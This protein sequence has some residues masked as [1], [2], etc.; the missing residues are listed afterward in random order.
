MTMTVKAVPIRFRIIFS[1]FYIKLST[2]GS[3]VRRTF[4]MASALVVSVSTIF[5]SVSFPLMVTISTVVVVPVIISTSLIMIITILVI[6][7][8]I[9]SSTIII[10]RLIIIMWRVMRRECYRSCSY[11]YTRNQCLFLR[12]TCGKKEGRREYCNEANFFKFC[13]YHFFP[14]YNS[15]YTCKL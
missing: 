15:F 14:S 1:P 9:V 5:S 13:L 11:C 10:I 8:I 6:P 4:I 3:V 2:S 12:C 7:T